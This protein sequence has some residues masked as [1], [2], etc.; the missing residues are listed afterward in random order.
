[1]NMQIKDFMCGTGSLEK[2]NFVLVEKNDKNKEILVSMGC[3]MEEINSLECEEENLID[4]YS[5]LKSKGYHFSAQK[6]FWK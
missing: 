4:V 2:F 5:L 6:G 1:M 3:S